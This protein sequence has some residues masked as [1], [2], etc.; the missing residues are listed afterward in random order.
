[1]ISSGRIYLSKKQA[2]LFVYSSSSDVENAS[3][4]K[5]QNARRDEYS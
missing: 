5:I 4:Y 2:L 1:M 3:K